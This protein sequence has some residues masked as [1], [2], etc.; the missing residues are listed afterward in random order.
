MILH[1][2]TVAQ[3]RPAGVR[4]GRVDRDDS[5]GLLLLA[6]VLGELIDQRALARSRRSSQTDHSRL[7]G[8]RE[9]RLEQIGTAGSAILDCRDGA[10]ERADVAGAQL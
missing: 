1:T 8:V 6:I 9:E 3:N 7:A 10:S 5:D 4:A 2:D